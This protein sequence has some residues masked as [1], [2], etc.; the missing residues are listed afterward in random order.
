MAESA[1]SVQCR[2]QLGIPEAA[3]VQGGKLQNQEWHF[4]SSRLF[5]VIIWN[6]DLQVEWFAW[7]GED[8]A[9]YAWRT[10]LGA[11]LSTWVFLQGWSPQSFAIFTP[12]LHEVAFGDRASCEELGEGYSA[13]FVGSGWRAEVVSCCHSLFHCCFPPGSCADLKYFFMYCWEMLLG[14]WV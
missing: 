3:A 10:G 13:W 12:L 14:I 5:L 11:R 9:N 2:A 4:Y 6:K 7:N 8:L 1:P